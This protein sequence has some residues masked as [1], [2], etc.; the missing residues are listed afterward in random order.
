MVLLDAA[1]LN[2]APMVGCLVVFP[3][4]GAPGH[5]R[6]RW[7]L[8]GDVAPHTAPTAESIRSGFL[9]GLGLVTEAC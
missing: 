8:E 1:P 2:G 5:G 3:A 6:C 7:A 4:E 9:E